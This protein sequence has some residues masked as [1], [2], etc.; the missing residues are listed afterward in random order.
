MKKL[1]SVITGMSLMAM[2]LI[3]LQ[4]SSAAG[5]TSVRWDKANSS[6]FAWSLENKAANADVANFV[7][8]FTPG[9]NLTNVIA[10]VGST[11]N[12]KFVVKDSA[13]AVMANSPVTLVLNPA[14]TFGTAVTAY[15]D[16]QE[17][18]KGFGDANDSRLVSLTTDS[19][20]AVTF[21]ITNKDTVG[22]NAI[23]NDG[24]TIPSGKQYTQLAIWQGNY[25]STSSRAAAQTSQD[26]D[27][28][29]IHFLTEAK[30]SAP[31]PTPTATATATPTPTPTVEAPKEFPSMRL[32][33]PAFGPSNSVDT[34]GGI[35]QY[36]SAKTRAFYTYIAAGTTLTL[37]YLVTKDG[38]TPLANTQVTLQVNSPYSGSKATWLSGSTKIGIPASES[39]SGADLTGTT[40]AAGEVTFN[41]KNTNTTGA[42]A[43]PASPNAAAPKV[44]LYGTL[45]PVIPGYG[46]KDA[47]VDL[48]TFDIYA[49]P[50]V[51]VKKTTITCVKGKTTKKVTAVKPKCPTGYKKK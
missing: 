9:V 11:L 1:I 29:E 46:D 38:T 31:T 14:Y 44:R 45:K 15:S 17:I 48:V 24:T 35:A 32:V 16:G 19:A 22:Q 3:F 36:Y 21:S 40:N 6:G 5:N 7:K 43:V 12:F 33:S 37:K 30:A 26:V 47:D 41:L 10:Q 42:E 39:A 8:Y 51:V 25:T 13:G 50:N 28:L 2:S 20:G 27:I 23:P 34:T 18:R 49:A 4:P